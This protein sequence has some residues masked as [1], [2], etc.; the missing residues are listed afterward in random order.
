M[1]PEYARGMTIAFEFAGSVLVFWLL[2]RWVDGWLDTAP[3]FQ[4]VGSLIGWGGGFAQVYYRA[5]RFELEEQAAK[6]RARQK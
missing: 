5:K 6:E 2:G 1:R 3:W 4:I